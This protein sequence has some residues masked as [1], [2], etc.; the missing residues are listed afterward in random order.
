MVCFADS[1]KVSI[2]FE[3]LLEEEE[4]SR[5]L[6]EKEV[7]EIEEYSYVYYEERKE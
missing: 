2:F 3:L 7:E 6:G 4:Y 1:S 5:L